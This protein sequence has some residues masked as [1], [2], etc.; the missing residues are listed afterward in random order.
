[1]NKKHKTELKTPK[2]L[3]EHTLNLKAGGFVAPR[4]VVH[5]KHGH[6]DCKP[7]GTGAPILQVATVYGWHPASLPQLETGALPSAGREAGSQQGSELR[8]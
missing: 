6:K 8:P 4:G 5:S 2:I 1:M 3:N 7:S